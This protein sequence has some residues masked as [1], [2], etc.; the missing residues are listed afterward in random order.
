MF[1]ISVVQH[2]KLGDLSSLQSGAPFT[3]DILAD[4]EM[5]VDAEFPQGT[6]HGMP[7]L[8][9]DEERTLVR[10]STSGFA[11]ECSWN[12]SSSALIHHRLGDLSISSGP[13]SLRTPS[14]RGRKKKYY[15]R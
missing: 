2:M 4:N 13:S 15:R 12:Y 5:R 6:E 3:D 1:I 14:R 7:A 9:L 10:D 11:G 8:S